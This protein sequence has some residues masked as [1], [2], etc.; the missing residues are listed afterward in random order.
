[1]SD[2]F[3]ENQSEA[4]VTS[5]LSNARR[6]FDNDNPVP[7]SVLTGN[8]DKENNLQEFRSRIVIPGDTIS[9]IPPDEENTEI[10]ED[11]KTGIVGIVLGPGLIREGSVVYVTKCGILRHKKP[12]THEIYWMDTH[13]K[14]YVPARGERVLGKPKGAL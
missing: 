3:P 13:S 9:E 14:R 11:T 2:S 6:Q 4:N 8:Q 5:F 10:E 7:T 1:M 12:S